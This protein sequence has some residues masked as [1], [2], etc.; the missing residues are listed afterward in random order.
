[1]KFNDAG[2][3]LIKS[4]EGCRLTTY[5]DIVGIKSIGYGHTGPDVKEGE[6]INQAMADLLLKKDL[7]VFTAGVTVLV[8]GV[9]LN[10]NEFS[11]LV[12]FAFNLGLHTL[13]NST[14]LRKIQLGDVSGAALEFPKWNHAGG[15]V[16]SGLTRRRSAEQALFRAPSV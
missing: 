15:E 13:A 7:E 16:V 11:A 5:E 6:T 4:F 9:N 8:H 10:D 14:L 2:L 1:M 3:A 12:S